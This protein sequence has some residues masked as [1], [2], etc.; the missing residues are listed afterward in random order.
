MWEQ[1]LYF[2]CSLQA[3]HIINVCIAFEHHKDKYIYGMLL[4]YSSLTHDCI[5]I[6]CCIV[7]VLNR[8]LLRYKRFTTNI[9]SM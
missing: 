8:Q 4:P 1:F 3:M 9:M 7:M 5:F 2:F 6:F